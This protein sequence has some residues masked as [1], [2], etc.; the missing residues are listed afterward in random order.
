[1]SDARISFHDK[2]VPTGFCSKV[3]LCFEFFFSS[4]SSTSRRDFGPREK[5]DDGE[6]FQ[7]VIF[8]G[9]LDRRKR[10]RETL[11]SVSNGG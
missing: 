2:S 3:V 5:R 1:M 10:A 6:G 11:K 8:I 4:S 9:V 7:F